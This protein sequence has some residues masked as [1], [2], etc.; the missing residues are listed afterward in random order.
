MRNEKKMKLRAGLDRMHDNV[1][2]L[3]NNYFRIHSRLPDFQC[4]DNMWIAVSDRINDPTVRA[5][6]RQVRCNGYI[7]Q[8][9]ETIGVILGIPQNVQDSLGSIE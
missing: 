7:R 1:T 5:R 9:D 3:V 6:L 8:P 4:L 2:T